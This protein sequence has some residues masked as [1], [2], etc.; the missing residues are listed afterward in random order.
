MI[1]SIKKKNS[2]FS[3]IKNEKTIIQSKK[4]DIK[5]LSFILNTNII[6]LYYNRDII[7]KNLHPKA[8][9]DYYDRK[10]HN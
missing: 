4:S 10:P 7:W 3:L 8:T 9:F 1:Y 2:L 5:L 6:F